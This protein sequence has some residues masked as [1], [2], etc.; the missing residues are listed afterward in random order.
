MANSGATWDDSNTCSVIALAISADW[1]YMDA[2][3]SMRRVGR[4]QHKGASVRQSAEALDYAGIKYN[5]L[6]KGAMKC[7]RQQMG[8]K[9]VTVNAFSKMFNKGTY[10]VVIAGHIFAMTD[11]VVH[12]FNTSGRGHV[13]CALEMLIETPATPKVARIQAELQF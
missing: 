9:V 10:Q 11:G 5:I 4:R 7:I 12:D 13:L 2:E 6:G 8:T 3:E 1:D